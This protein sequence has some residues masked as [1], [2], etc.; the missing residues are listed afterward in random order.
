MHDKPADAMHKSKNNTLLRISSDGSSAFIP[1]ALLAIFASSVISFDR[2]D[3]RYAFLSKWIDTMPEPT[4]HC[5]EPA[6][7]TRHNTSFEKKPFFVEGTIASKRI[8]GNFIPT[9]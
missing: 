5:N 9:A 3:A 2:N 6:R 8:F 4:A 1:S 7:A